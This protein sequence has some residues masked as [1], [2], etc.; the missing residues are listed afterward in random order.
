[1]KRVSVGNFRFCIRRWYLGGH[2]NSKKETA[3]QTSG[4]GDLLGKG[5]SMYG[6]P[7]AGM[8]PSNRKEDVMSETEGKRRAWGGLKLGWQDQA[9]RGLMGWERSGGQSAMANYWLLSWPEAPGTLMLLTLDSAASTLNL[10]YNPS[11]RT[12]GLSHDHHLPMMGHNSY[13]LE[14]WHYKL[15]TVPSLKCHPSVISTVACWVFVWIFKNYSK[16]AMLYT[17]KWITNSR[18]SGSSREKPWGFLQ[19]STLGS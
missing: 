16:G 14:K 5:N 17:N 8:R 12:L 1:M 19:I 9:T 13:Q 11:G 6:G 18:T 2:L 7:E 3:T 4:G 15:I 10:S